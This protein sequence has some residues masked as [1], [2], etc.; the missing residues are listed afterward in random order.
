MSIEAL[1]QRTT[2][3]LSGRAVL[4]CFVAFFGVIAAVNAI[5]IRAA[6]STFGGVETESAY[7]AGLSFKNEIAA[8]RAQEARH[9]EVLGSAQ[10]TGAGGVAIDVRVGNTSASS[11][12]TASVRFA[13]PTNARFDHH[14]ALTQIGPGHFIG[15]ADVAAGQ[16]DFVIDLSRGDERVF[17]SKNRIGLH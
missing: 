5:M 13:H 11:G 2:R 16:W 4:L 17:R 8:A 14:T 3:E 7:K 1:Q 12:L 10:R 15:S 6:T 9:L